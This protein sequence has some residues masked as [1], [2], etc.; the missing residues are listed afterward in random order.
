MFRSTAA[1][2]S[3]SVAPRTPS[4]LKIAAAAASTFSRF[5]S[6]LLGLDSIRSGAG[7][8]GPGRSGA[9]KFGRA[10]MT[11]RNTGGR[12]ERRPG[13]HLLRGKD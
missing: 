9:A 10:V 8:S 2:T 6:N 13:P 1:A 3:D 11:L 5:L 4:R 12:R 7:R